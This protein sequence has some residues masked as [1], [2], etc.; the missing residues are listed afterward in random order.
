MQSRINDLMSQEAQEIADTFGRERRT[1]LSSEDVSEVAAPEELV[2]DERCLV[3]FSTAGHIKRVSDSEFI[4]QVCRVHCFIPLQESGC[5][6]SIH[7][8]NCNTAQ[9]HADSR[10]LW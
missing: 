3:I 9:K 4:T 6:S 1:L 7:N 8:T 5:G 2:P 10:I